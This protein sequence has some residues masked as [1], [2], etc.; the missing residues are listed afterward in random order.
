[1][2]ST[3]SPLGVVSSARDGTVPIATAAAEA[4]AGTHSGLLVDDSG[5]DQLARGAAGEESH[6]DARALR[7]AAPAIVVTAVAAAERRRGGDDRGR[8]RAAPGRR[9]AHRLRRQHQPRAEDAGRRARGARRDAGRRGRPG[10]RPPPGRQDGRRGAPCGAHDRRPARAVTDRARRGADPRSWST[11]VDIVDGAVERRPP[12][13]PS[14]ATSRSRRSSVPDDVHVCRRPPP[15]GLG[16]RQPGRERRQVQRA[17]IERA[18]PRP[19]RG[20]RGSSSW[21]PIT[22]SA[23]RPA[24]STGSSSGSTA[25]TRPAAAT[26]AAPG[27]ACRSFATSPPTTVATS[28]CRRRR[29]RAPR[30]CCASRSAPH[31]A[32]RRP[33][34]SRLEESR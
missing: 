19:R 20:A 2:S 14:A 30:S 13:R 25:S 24:T 28:R 18:G 26:P 21:S 23:S 9:R 11:V 6:A 34:E 31:V 27:S 10:R 15:A 32:S 22:A 5:E 33:G 12:A 7:A 1:M 3:G 4:L 29:A 17:G 8:Q 16:A